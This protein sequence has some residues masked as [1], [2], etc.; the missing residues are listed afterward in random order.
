MAGQ[1]MQATFGGP[2]GQNLN[3]LSFEYNYAYTPAGKVSSKTLE[4]QSANNYGMY[5]TAYGTLTA[6]YT[7]DNQGAETIYFY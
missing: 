6:S 3:Q 4:V 2:P 5:G 7:Y 1:L